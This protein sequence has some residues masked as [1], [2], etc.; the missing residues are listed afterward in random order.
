[1]KTLISLALVLMV[2]LSACNQRQLLQSNFESDVIGSAPNKSLPGDPIGD[3]IIYVREL[4]RR[5]RVDVAPDLEGKALF[6]SGR[7]SGDPSLPGHDNWVSFVGAPT[8]SKKNLTISWNGRFS[9]FTDPSQKVL[10]DITNGA[11]VVMVRLQIYN[12]GRVY[13]ERDFVGGAARLIGTINTAAWNYFI[14]NADPMTR[15]F[16]I[17]IV[18]ERG[19][20]IQR[21]NLAFLD[22]GNTVNFGESMRPAISYQ[23]DDSAG[24]TSRCIVDGIVIRQKN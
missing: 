16:R 13:A 17:L 24:E 6:Y 18:R 9:G 23:I 19:D 14:V 20:N 21:E 8:T 1:M 10:I 5:L 12:D 3:T 22:Y 2:I 4:T 7:R 11:G 15:K